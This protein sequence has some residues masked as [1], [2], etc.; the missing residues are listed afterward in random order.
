LTTPGY[1]WY[2]NNAAAYKDTYGAMYNWYAV[3]T[4]KLAPTGWHVPT[5][6]DFT[7]LTTYLGGVSNAG[8]KLKEAGTSHWLSPNEGATNEAGFT[9]LP[10]GERFGNGGFYYMTDRGYWWCSTEGDGGEAWSRGMTSFYSEVNQILGTK[11]L[12][13]SVRCVKN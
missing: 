10:G 8:G 12:G 4:G 1:C 6:D 3:N 9:A 7:V 5:H 11:E 2:N 13:F